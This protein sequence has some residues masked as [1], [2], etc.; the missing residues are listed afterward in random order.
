MRTSLRKY[1]QQLTTL[2][3]ICLA[4]FAF[5]Q[6]DTTSVPI[7]TS[8]I[9]DTAIPIDTT[10]ASI[11]TD[12]INVDSSIVEVKQNIFE[13]DKVKLIY[14][15]DS[16]KL[17]KN[18][19]V[20]NLIKII[21]VSSEPISFTVTNIYPAVWQT[22][23]VLE[24]GFKVLQPNDTLFYPILLIPSKTYRQGSNLI[25]NT[26]LEDSLN[27]TI[28]NHYF[29]IY[30]D[31]QISWETEV[32]PD[33]KVYL[34]N[35]ETSGVIKY[36]ISNT[37]PYKQDFFIS[38]KTLGT[39]LLVSDT[40]DNILEPSRT[41]SLE[42]QA[43]TT[44]F[45]KLSAF[46]ENDRN[47]KRV[48][49]LNYV[50]NYKYGD[51]KYTMFLES[52]DPKELR[53]VNKKGDKIDFIKL[54]NEIIASDMSNSTLPLVVEAA[55]QNIFDDN[56]FMSL[57]MRGF[58]TLNEDAS[59][60]YFTQ[61]NYS[62]A[63]LGTQ[64]VRNAPWYVGY[65]DSKIQAEIGQV[66]GN[67]IGINNF[68]KGAKFS[69]R[70]NDKHQTG[71]FYTR[72]LRIFEPPRTEGVGLY[73]KFNVNQN[74]RFKASLGRSANYFIDS[75]TNAA[76][77]SSNFSIGKNH[78]FSLLAGATNSN[79]VFQATNYTF[80]GLLGSF[81]YS[82]S[83]LDRKI[84]TSLNA[85]Y[86]DRFFGDGG[87]ENFQ[88]NHLSTY[89]INNK[90]RVN[91]NNFYFDNAAYNI[92]EDTLYFGQNLFNNSAVFHTTNHIGTFQPGVFYNYSDI[93]NYKVH[94]RGLLFRY[95][96]GDYTKNFLV[97]SFFRAGYNDA[98][99]FPDL[100]NFFILE[101]NTILR[102]RVWTINT[103]YMYGAN[104]RVALEHMLAYG[105]TPQFFRFNMQNQHLFKNEH[106]VIENSF[107]YTYNNIFK[108]HGIGYFPQLF[109]FTN[110]GWR[111]AINAS[112]NFYS[113]DY[114]SFYTSSFVPIEELQGT[115]V[116]NYNFGFSVRKEFDIP[117][118]FLKSKSVDCN[119]VAF[120]DLNGNSI[121]EENEP[122]IENVIINI[123][124]TSELITDK[125]GVGKVK[126][127]SLGEHYVFVKR[128]EGIDGWFSNIGDSL[129]VITKGNVYLPFV[130]GVKVYGE[131]F[132]DRQ[133]IGVVDKDKKFD[134][135]RIKITATNGKTH[136][137]LTD[138]DGKFEFYL[139]NGDYLIT[140]DENVLGTKYKM[141]SNNI[142]VKLAY[143]Q[144]DTYVSFYVSEKRR[145]VTIKEF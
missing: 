99:D 11:N 64:F 126:N 109:Y 53:R 97:S 1:K 40:S 145:K 135:S 89:K 125:N 92:F 100:K 19:V 117:I 77:L 90:W 12:S 102:Y 27:Q 115:E 84:R 104:S 37:G 136:H 110:S 101:N 32:N 25:I 95:S 42:S 62:T 45:Y 46:R 70:F 132:L 96:K 69:Y 65:F 63:F 7:D 58:K 79:R 50:P 54:P 127:I 5:G 17:Q 21:N 60:I 35:N 8:S 142:P 31:K 88:I 13:N 3:L 128:L 138:V 4:N 44:L 131:V 57:N 121:K 133:E 107:N 114:G 112:Y 113:N 78:H 61:F 76:N 85:R 48:P 123:D 72:G 75:R 24:E 20:T 81:N 56:V 14:R 130:R 9:D 141:S 116:H 140:M 16:V 86:N 52:R 68:G 93:L 124:N 41:V 98:I 71:V 82:T 105:L 66:S 103:R 47:F 139:P 39:N 144:T 38:Y 122:T 87:F 33:R 30:S 43:D 51:K 74:L 28:G 49:T 111:F 22:V 143:G 29:N 67:I 80:N 10:I 59:L 34:K 26:I 36:R 94:S 120:Y 137:T 106:F 55:A 108:R 18:E 119:F 134:L 118:P 129:E 83:F 73:H 15:L 6:I 23:D 2:L 91:L